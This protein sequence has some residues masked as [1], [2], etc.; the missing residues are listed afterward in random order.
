MLFGI[1][2][3]TLAQ[4]NAALEFLRSAGLRSYEL[5]R[6]VHPYDANSVRA[7]GGTIVYIEPSPRPSYKDSRTAAGIDVCGGDWVLCGAQ[8]PG[9]YL[10]R[11][12]ALISNNRFTG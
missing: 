2:A 12:L 9:E 1:S 3:P 11:L 8:H 6:V 10:P 7:R 5:A 4:I